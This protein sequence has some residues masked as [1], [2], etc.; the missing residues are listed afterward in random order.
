VGRMAGMYE[1]AISIF[2]GA[3]L[4]LPSSP[5]PHLLSVILALSIGV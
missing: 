5:V 1:I 3:T 4:S 2:I